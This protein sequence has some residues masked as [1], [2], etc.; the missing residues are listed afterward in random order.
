MIFSHDADYNSK[1]LDLAHEELKA[2]EIELRAERRILNR[3]WEAMSPRA[4]SSQSR[5]VK[6]LESRGQALS[7]TIEILSAL[8]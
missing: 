6:E 5:V 7:E 8:I 2:V 3:D 4:R 1:D